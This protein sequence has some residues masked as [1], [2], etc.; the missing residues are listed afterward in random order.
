MVNQL[1]TTR[2][3]RI[4]A[5]IR[6]KIHLDTIEVELA[7]QGYTRFYLRSVISPTMRSSNI[8][9]RNFW[10]RITRLYRHRIVKHETG[11]L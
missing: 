9:A 4:T 1:E 6:A 2:M 7:S 5:I 3:S 10:S 11:S 8:M